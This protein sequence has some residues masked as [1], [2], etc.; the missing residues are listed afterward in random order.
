MF[1][2]ATYKD[3]Q[4]IYECMEELRQ[5]HVNIANNIS[6]HFFKEETTFEEIEEILE[7]NTKMIFIIKLQN[8][9]VGVI[10][11]QFIKKSVHI[12]Q[13]FIKEKYRSQGIGKDC[14]SFIENF[15]RE[16]ETS[17]DKTFIAITLRVLAEN[18][19]AKCFYDRYGFKENIKLSSPHSKYM[20]KSL[21]MKGENNEKNKL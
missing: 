10:Y 14:L 4:F 6:K 11:L 12:S 20:I 15:S 8:R 7:S 1:H 2:K 13:L 16:I 21:R 9:K 18:T 5:Y 3:R 17:K 19:Q